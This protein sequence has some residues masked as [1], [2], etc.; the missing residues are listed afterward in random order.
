MKA[1]PSSSLVLV[2]YSKL[3]KK[4]ATYTQEGA[5]Q[6]E[7]SC[8]NRA[9]VR[10]ITARL[11][12]ETFRPAGVK[13]NLTLTPNLTPTPTPTL[14]RTAPEEL[15]TDV[16]APRLLS[17][18]LTAAADFAALQLRRRQDVS[19]NRFCSSRQ[20]EDRRQFT[21]AN[22]AWKKGLESPRES[23]HVDAELPWQCLLCPH[24]AN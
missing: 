8:R 5:G 11:G 1:Q 16:R 20:P 10:E 3:R 6:R 9:N 23:F 13:G 2:W 18:L 15:H 14:T 24:E 4:E 19:S 17:S 22:L 12:C 7:Q 21:T